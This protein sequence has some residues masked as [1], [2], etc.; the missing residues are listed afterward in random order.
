MQLIAKQPYV[1]VKR[2]VHSIEQ[3]HTELN[4]E[5]LLYDDRVVTKHREFPIGDVLD[6]SYRKVGGEAGLLYL[7]TI[8]GVYSY[9]VKASPE[10]FIEEFKK[11]VKK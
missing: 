1:K 2:E 8:K 10:E 9:T 7:H 5:L 6:M 11:L 4:R 3:V